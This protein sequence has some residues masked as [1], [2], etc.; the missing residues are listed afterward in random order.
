MGAAASLVE[1]AWR[2]RRGRDDLLVLTRAEVADVYASLLSPERF[3]RAYVRTALG[4]TRW[5]DNAED[6]RTYIGEDMQGDYWGMAD[7]WF[8]RDPGLMRGVFSL[9]IV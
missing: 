8:G 7:L 1:R 3:V 5:I 4:K 9:A 2:V 6:M